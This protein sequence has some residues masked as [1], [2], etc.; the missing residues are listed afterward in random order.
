[1]SEPPTAK[2]IA[3]VT[4]RS[5]ATEGVGQMTTFSVA[6]MMLTA[7]LGAGLLHF[8]AAY[9]IAGGIL[10][11]TVLQLILAV[12]IGGTVLTLAFCADVKN[13]RTYQ[14]IVL[15]M[16]GTKWR[17]ASAASVLLFCYGI[18][19]VY[20]I[21][22]GDQY[23]R[24]FCH[25]WYMARE[26]TITLTAV[27]I[28]LPL[29]MLQH[30]EFLKCASSLGLVAVVYPCVLTGIEYYTV[31][32]PDDLYIKVWPTSARDV[33]LS[34]PVFCFAYQMAPEES[35]ST[36]GVWWL[37]GE[38]CETARRGESGPSGRC[39]GAAVGTE[40]RKTRDRSP[41][42][43]IADFARSVIELSARNFRVK[44]VPTRPLKDESGWHALQSH[45]VVISA[46]AA[47]RQRSMRNMAQAIAICM[48]ILFVI[49]STVGCF[50]YLTYGASVRPDIMEM[51]D[52]KQAWVL[53]GL[54]ALILK[55][56]FTYPLLALCARCRSPPS[57]SP[58]MLCIADARLRDAIEELYLQLRGG[59]PENRK[60]EHA[61]KTKVSLAWF[62][63][64]VGVAILPLDI[65]VAIKFLG[66][67]SALN[68]FLFPGM[69]LLG[70]T[71]LKG[72]STTY[73]HWLMLLGALMVFVGAVLFLVV[74]LHVLLVDL[75]SGQVNHL[76][77]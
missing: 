52:A 34:A 35:M 33:F 50:G 74:F 46:Y 55:M 6:L 7:A 65:G 31:P 29:S 61:R 2:E 71:Q 47:M 30:I 19:V 38:V 67:L 70:Y 11:A 75:V 73:R 69:C 21:V 14:G 10:M 66:C 77:S 27:A 42:L 51:F 15:S 25:T 54:V 76:C 56:A 40:M 53:I 26:F 18:C 72:S 68:V 62:A 48:A 23:D 13:D 43:R 59:P 12:S 63:T 3:E 28:V 39:G 32:R 8:P 49:Y 41:P 1:M 16:C 58:D 36:L 9:N 44:C 64:T 57:G 17:Y 45:E 4:P 24:N 5:D 37:D 20:L 60:E 22:I